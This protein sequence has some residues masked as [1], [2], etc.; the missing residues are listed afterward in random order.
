MVEA[1]SEL[2]D[3]DLVILRDYLDGRIDRDT[4]KALLMKYEL[5]NEKQAERGLAFYDANRAYSINYRTG[6]ELVKQWIDAKVAG[7]MDRWAAM[8]LLLSSP[9][10][11]GE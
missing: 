10:V 7:G 8:E 1:K 6:E 11:L 3:V 2:D 5:R 9:V 4:A